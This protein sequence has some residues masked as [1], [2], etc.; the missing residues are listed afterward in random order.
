MTVRPVAWA[1]GHVTEMLL[2]LYKRTIFDLTIRGQVLDMTVQRNVPRFCTG[3]ICGWNLFQPLHGLLY[4]EL[5]YSA[6]TDIQDNSCL[7]CKMKLANKMKWI[8]LAVWKENIAPCCTMPH[9]VGTRFTL[10]YTRS[11]CSLRPNQQ[12]PQNRC[13]INVWPSSA[14]LAQHRPNIGRWIGC[15]WTMRG[16]MRCRVFHAL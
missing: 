2:I 16:A 4:L 1:C 15:A 8:E 5:L 12:D 13:W 14:T 9:I 6:S 10:C 7:L 3:S 11:R